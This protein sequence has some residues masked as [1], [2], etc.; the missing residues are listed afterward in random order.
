MQQFIFRLASNTVEETQIHAA[1]NNSIQLL[2]D[3]TSTD[4]ETWD[5]YIDLRMSDGTSDIQNLGSSVSVTFNLTSAHTKLGKLYVNPYVMSGTSRKGF[6][7]KVIEIGRQLVNGS[8]TATVQAY[9]NGYI[10]SRLTVKAVNTTTLGAGSPATFGVTVKSDGTT[11]D[12]GI[13]K[14]DVQ[15]KESIGLGN[16][17]NTSDVNKPIS[18]AT[19]TE[20]SKK[21]NKRTITSVNQ[22]SGVTKNAASNVIVLHGIDKVNNRLIFVDATWGWLRQ[23]DNYGA[24]YSNQKG[25]PSDVSWSNFWKVVTFKGY[26]YCVAKTTTDNLVKVFRALPADGNN[27]FGWSSPLLVLTSGSNQIL[28]TA[29]DSDNSYI[30][31]GEY[32]DPVGGPSIYRSADGTTWEKT[33]GQDSGIRHI[34]AIK[35]DPY[36][37]GHVWFTC[38]DGINKSIQKSTD[39]GATWQI[40]VPLPAWQG[41]QISFDENWVYVAGDSAKGTYIVI[42]R[43]TNTPRMAAQ[44]YHAHI[45]VPAGAA[46]DRFYL[47]AFYGLVDPLTGIYYCIANDPSSGGNRDGF[48]YST[49]VG[50]PI[51]LLDHLVSPNTVSREMFLIGGK[52]WF[53]QYRYSLIS[54]A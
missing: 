7:L 26:L 35:S 38:G 41:V 14:G 9:I 52:I 27:A 21:A 8:A 47:N 28:F 10:D 1:D 33:Y 29:F 43:A 46:G 6:P 15:T 36:N 11:Y 54:L 44:N 23:S 16:V 25:F 42:D 19:Q 22:F 37:A 51:Y 12:V 20:L 34:H 39:Y 31:I 4:Y 18:T 17:D 30:Y 32:G 40:V 3:F 49:G 53:G 48:F 24:T 50:E 2:L 5:K 45:A 13:P